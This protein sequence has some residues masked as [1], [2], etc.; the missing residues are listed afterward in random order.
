MGSLN[1]F[2]NSSNQISLWW[3]KSGNQGNKWLKGVVGIGARDKPFQ[4]IFRGTN[5]QKASFASILLDLFQTDCF[6]FTD[7]DTRFKLYRVIA[8]GGRRVV[9]R[10]RKVVII[11]IIIVVVVIIMSQCDSLVNS[12][13]VILLFVCLFVC[14]HRPS[15]QRKILHRGHRSRRFPVPGVRPASCRLQ[16]Q[17]ILLRPRFL[18][19]EQQEVRFQRRLR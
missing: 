10:P 12:T 8:R 17:S 15:C 16:L 18:C 2:V 3:R 1:V 14:L 11:I 5:G 4:I 13:E 6:E 9:C 7:G 19:V